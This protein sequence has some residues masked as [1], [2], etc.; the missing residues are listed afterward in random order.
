MPKCTLIWV[1]LAVGRL[2][3]AS[4]FVKVFTVKPCVSCTIR[5]KWPMI[6]IFAPLRT[7]Q[8]GCYKSNCIKVFTEMIQHGIWTTQKPYS[9]KWRE[10]V[11]TDMVLD[12]KKHLVLFF[13]QSI[14]TE[15]SKTKLNQ[16]NRNKQLFPNFWSF[17]RSMSQLTGIVNFDWVNS[18]KRSTLASKNVSTR[19]EKWRATWNAFNSKTGQN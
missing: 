3:W 14:T 8:D 1:L 9:D 17:L 11:R 5:C 13:G 2:K 4:Y 7:R 12:L 16:V 6:Q 15:V 19:L 18:W 10:Y